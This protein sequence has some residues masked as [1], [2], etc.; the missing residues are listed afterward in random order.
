MY[1]PRYD[2]NLDLF[3][4][5]TY[6]HAHTH[7]HIH[8]PLSQLLFSFTYSVYLQLWPAVI[9]EV[10]DESDPAVTHIWSTIIF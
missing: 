3:L 5:D 6:M 4:P 8:T 7:V 1:F 9:G 2:L 10:T